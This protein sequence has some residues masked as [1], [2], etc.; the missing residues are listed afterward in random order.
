MT[1]A[2]LRIQRIQHH[3]KGGREGG[4]EGGKE[5]GKEGDGG[6]EGGKE[7]DGGGGKKGKITRMEVVRKI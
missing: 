3:L 4:R 1:V 7:G 5:G 6:K 2:L